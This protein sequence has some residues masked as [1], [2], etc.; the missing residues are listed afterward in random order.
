MEQKQVRLQKVLAEAGIASRRKAEELI[1]QGYVSVNN[2]KVSTLG[3]K[4]SSKDEIRVDGILVEK[5]EPKHYYLLYKPSGVITSVRDPQGRQTV[6]DLMK[7]V[8]V[9]VYPVGRLDYETSGILLLTNDGELANR[10]IHPSFG[11]EKTYWAWVKGPVNTIALNTL[12]SGVQLDDG[13]TAP[14]KVKILNNLAEGGL[15]ILELTIH[16]GRN[17][18]VRRMCAAV[19]YPVVKLERIRF[20]PLHKDSRLHPGEFRPLRREEIASLL[21]EVR[22]L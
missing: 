11:V 1:L 9:R 12:R 21:K 22:L 10:L 7:D 8:L 5:S 17:R 14:A 15:Q 19:G 20:G 3:T 13:K 6:L 16:E 18:Q 2:Q 4:V